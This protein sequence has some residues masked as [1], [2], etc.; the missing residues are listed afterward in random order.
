MDTA[1]PLI[2]EQKHRDVKMYAVHRGIKL[3]DA[4]DCVITE[5]LKALK[6]ESPKIKPG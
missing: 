2:P 5:G 4:Y 3:T 6:F 1:Q